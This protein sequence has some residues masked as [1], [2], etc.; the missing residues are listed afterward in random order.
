[1][2]RHLAHITTSDSPSALS[3]PTGSR[4]SCSSLSPG[5]SCDSQWGQITTARCRRTLLQA[6][7]LAHATCKVVFTVL[8]YRWRN[9]G[10]VFPLDES[11]PFVFFFLFF[12]IYRKK[13]V[14]PSLINKTANF[15]LNHNS[16]TSSPLN[17]KSLTLL[18]DK[19]MLLL[20][21]TFSHPDLHPDLHVWNALTF[22]FCLFKSCLIS[23]P[24]LRDALSIHLGH[25]NTYHILFGD[26]LFFW[27]LIMHTFSQL[28]REP[29][30]L[31]AEHS[32]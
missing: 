6:L 16:L 30:C 2:R 28:N 12:N 31:A 1:M 19:L 8:F 3:V 7:C 20:P 26:Q 11:L 18:I 4:V 9:R 21:I 32:I 17:M 27:L 5:S 25:E 15:L 14:F 22:S 24:L 10:S 23:V 13:T 29:T